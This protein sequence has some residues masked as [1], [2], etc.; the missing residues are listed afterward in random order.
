MQVFET[1]SQKNLRIREMW[2]FTPADMRRAKDELMQRRI[3]TETRHA[4]ELKAI[5]AQ[6][7]D[8]TAMEQAI[9]AFACKYKPAALADEGEAQEL[10]TT[11]M[12]Q[13][14]LAQSSENWGDALFT[15]ATVARED[16]A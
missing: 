15:P 3:A 6:L 13:A 10:A 5:D 2:S 12:T 14:K 8:I 7:A 11:L 1:A 9:E 16:A 4:D